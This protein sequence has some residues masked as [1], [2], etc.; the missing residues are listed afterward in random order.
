[1]LNDINGFHVNAGHVDDAI[2]AA[3]DGRIAEGSVGG[4]TGMICHG[5]KG[6]IGTASRVRPMDEGGFTVGVLV[7][8]NHGRRERLSVNGA[9]VG[10]EIGP[11]E[12]PLPLDPAVQSPGEAGS[13]IV[14]VATDAPLLPSQCSR[15]AQRAGLGVARTGGV[16]EHASG[17]M[18]LCF[19]T[20]N[21]GMIAGQPG[22]R[23]PVTVPLTMLSDSYI[24]GLFDA[25]VEA[26][27]EA[28][29]NA[30]LTTQTMVGRDGI[31]AYGL[32]GEAVSGVLAA[33]RGTTKTNLDV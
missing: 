12:I 20:G 31:T 10:L 6:G 19:A 30:L 18:F 21:R 16:G 9:P 3:S 28:I 1:M 23:G 13:I 7:Q 11:S 4:G 14:V 26:T 29:L 5:F 32:P 8:A 25:V 15:L 17:D 22:H 27:E 24:T 33:H 2:A